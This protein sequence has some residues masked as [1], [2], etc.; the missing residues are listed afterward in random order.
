MH[1]SW[2]LHRRHAYRER[3]VPSF[4]PR[5][6]ESGKMRSFAD[7]SSRPF[8][9]ACD[10]CSAHSTLSPGRALLPRAA[11]QSV[12][13]AT[14]QSDHLSCR[15]LRLNKCHQKVF[16]IYQSKHYSFIVHEI[17]LRNTDKTT[18]IRDVMCTQYSQ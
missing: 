2:F 16:V 14:K 7:H 1:V 11:M 6:T 15:E 12:E 10:S 8:N 4:F 13:C 17:S 3:K 5:T 9:Y 18:L